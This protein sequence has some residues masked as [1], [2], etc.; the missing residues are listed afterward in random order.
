M[1]ENELKIF[2]CRELNIADADGSDL[3][4]GGIPEWTSGSHMN[5]IISLEEALNVE[6]SSDEIVEM[7]DVASIAKV[8][9]RKSA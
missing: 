5:V 7:T 1:T 4:Y 2:I 8:I 6:F 3:S 9:D